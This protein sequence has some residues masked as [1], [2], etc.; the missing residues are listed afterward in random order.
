MRTLRAIHSFIIDEM[1]GS[2]NTMVLKKI[3]KKRGLL[4]KEPS[5]IFPIPFTAPG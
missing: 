4:F 3:V 5:F 2:E 1:V